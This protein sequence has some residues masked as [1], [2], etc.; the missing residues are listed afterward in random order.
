M[1]ELRQDP[2][3][4]NWIIIATERAKR[5]SSFKSI[6]E[7]KNSSSN[8]PFCPGHETE[9]PSEVLCFR[10]KDTK[11]NTPGWQ[12]RVVPNK[13]AALSPEAE[14]STNKDNFFHSMNGM[15]V[16]EVIIEGP[17]HDKFFSELKHEHA[18]L[19]LKAWQQRHRQLQ[20]N[21]N[22]KY[23]QIFKNHGKAAGAS[24]EH[25]HSQLIATPLI[26]TSTQMEIE[27]LKSYHD[28]NNSCLI[29]DLLIKELEAG[30]RIITINKD[31]IAFC[32]FASRF[33]METWIVPQQ[34][35][36][37]FNECKE[38]QLEMLAATLQDILGRLRQIADDPPF[39]LVLYTAPLQQKEQLY[40]WH[41]KLL[42]RL[43][44]VAGFELGTGIHINPTPPEIAAQYFNK[45]E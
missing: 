40:H 13:Y 9:T 37:S 27:R 8:C 41:F 29:C 10:D 3:S 34:H 21:K 5:P 6:Q 16:H 23:I 4:K 24:L 31:F 12:V 45:N 17:E 30:F 36:A 20:Q 44:I 43:S 1:P 32:P 18:T 2:V 42:P 26:P 33:P 35:Q 22:L 19:I 14:V 28:E 11:P 7:G 39:N 25:P 38:E 15:G